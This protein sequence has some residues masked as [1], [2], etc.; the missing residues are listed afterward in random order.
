MILSSLQRLSR[1]RLIVDAGE[2]LAVRQLLGTPNADTILVTASRD[3]EQARDGGPPQNAIDRRLGEGEHK[4]LLLGLLLEDARDADLIV[5]DERLQGEPEGCLVGVGETERRIVD[6]ERDG[7]RH[8]LRRARV[9]VD[10]VLREAQLHV[11]ARRALPGRVRD[12]HLG[13]RTVGV[14]AH[15]TVAI[16]PDDGEIVRRIRGGCG[17]CDRISEHRAPPS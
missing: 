16:G 9:G 6:R 15:R 4:D 2:D 13:I 5:V 3:R 14:E 11:V 10:R 1:L 7:R 8:A 12:R 17:D